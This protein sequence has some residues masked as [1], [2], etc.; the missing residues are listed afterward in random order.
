M[1]LLYGKVIVAFVRM[2]DGIILMHNESGYSIMNKRRVKTI[3]LELADFIMKTYKPSQFQ[4][5][6][7]HS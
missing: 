2:N 4:P 6:S 7:W 3:S 1:S 5:N